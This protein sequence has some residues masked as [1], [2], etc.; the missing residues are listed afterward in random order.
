MPMSDTVLLRG[1]GMAVIYGC[2]KILSYDAA[3]VCL[4]IA[5]RNVSV[6]GSELVCTAFSAGAVT[7]EGRIDGVRYCQGGCMGHCPEMMK[8]SE[9]TL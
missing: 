3:R 5:H 1:T 9:G 8:E 4:S 2:R 6:F 7:V